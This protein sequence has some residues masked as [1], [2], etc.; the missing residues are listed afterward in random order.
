MPLGC[1]SGICCAVG[2]DMQRCRLD[3]TS[4]IRRVVMLC[5]APWPSWELWSRRG[6]RALRDADALSELVFSRALWIGRWRRVL[7]CWLVVVCCSLRMCYYLL[8]A[9]VGGDVVNDR[10]RCCYHASRL[11]DDNVGAEAGGREY[12]CS[13]LSQGQGKA[14][15]RGLRVAHPTPMHPSARR[16]FPTSR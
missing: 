9:C 16:L 10:R 7:G 6:G 1:N 15:Q 11:D 2:M 3:E 12:G 13:S 4:E 8:L 14:R 5:C